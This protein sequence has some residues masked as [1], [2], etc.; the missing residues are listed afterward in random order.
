MAAPPV[1]HSR[2]R[3]IPFEDVIIL[4]EVISLNPFDDAAMWVKV[5]EKLGDHTQVVRSVRSVKESLYLLLAQF[6]R[7]DTTNRRKS[8]SEEEYEAVDRLLQQVADL[9]RERGYRPARS[10]VR[11]HRAGKGRPACA[12]ARVARPKNRVPDI[13][14]SI[15]L[16]ISTSASKEAD[17]DFG[18]PASA[19][20]PQSPRSPTPRS[21]MD[22]PGARGQNEATLLYVEARSEQ[23]MRMRM[24]GHD[25][26]RERLALQIRQHEDKMQLQMHQHSDNVRLRELELELRKTELAAD[27]EERRTSQAYQSAQLE[28]NKTLT[29]KLQKQSSEYI[30]PSFLVDCF[31]QPS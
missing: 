2:R 18:Q 1:M 6:L 9:A 15:A 24:L 22:T 30:M 8:G 5:A 12:A 14:Q 27:L 17:N 21:P 13:R 11:S 16:K 7:Q 26:D 31:F 25:L 10:A 19:N 28:L 23:E 29:E 4:E 20:A 3:Y